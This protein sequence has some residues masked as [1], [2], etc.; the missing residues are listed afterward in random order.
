MDT[1]IGFHEQRKHLRKVSLQ[2]KGWKTLS[3]NIFVHHQNFAFFYNQIQ[4][5]YEMK[6]DGKRQRAKEPPWPEIAVE[7]LFIRKKWTI[8]KLVGRTSFFELRFYKNRPTVVT[9]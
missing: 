1:C 7:T 9:V 5:Q 6:N 2:Y 4:P 3:P 8:K